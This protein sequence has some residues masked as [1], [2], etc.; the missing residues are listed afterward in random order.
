MANVLYNSRQYDRMIALCRKTL[1]LNYSGAWEKY[2]HECLGRG[3]IQKGMYQEA[4]SEMR[5]AVALDRH[6]TPLSW[7]GYIYAVGGRKR[8]ARKILR[9][10]EK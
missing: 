2:S 10:M 9:E 7:L 4:M 8:E 6:Y 1:D 3:F 5:R